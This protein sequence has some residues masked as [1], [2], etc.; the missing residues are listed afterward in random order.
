MKSRIGAHITTKGSCEFTVWAPAAQNVEV[1]LVSKNNTLIP[2]QKQERGYWKSETSE[3]KVGDLYLYQL[4]G[5]EIWPDPASSYQPQDVHG[6]SAIVDHA[7]FQWKDNAWKGLALK[8][9]IVYELHVGTFTPEGTFEGVVTKLD[10]LLD[11][12]ITTIEL[13]P[14]GQFPGNRNWGYDGVFPFAVQHS[15]GGPEGLKKLINACHEKGIAVLVDAV[16]NHLGPEGNCL[17]K[18]GPYCT[19]KY[20]IP[21]GNAMNFD[22]AHSDEVRN[23]FIQNALMWFRDYHVDGLRLD[24]VDAYR[25]MR[26]EHFL[27]ELNK[28][29]KQLE[30]EAGRPLYLMGES[31][32]NDSKYIV[33][34]EKGGYGLDVHWADEFHHALHSLLTG[35]KSGY[36][37]DYG[38]VKDL[39]KAFETSFVH[40]GQYSNFRNKTFGTSTE[41]HPYTQFLVFAQN[42][43]Q[44]GNRLLADRLS[45]CIS[46]EALKLMAG[47]V[48]ISPSIPL[49]F[50]GEEFGEETPFQFFTS[51]SDEKLIKESYETRQRTFRE[52]HVPV[53]APH[54]QSESL[55]HGSKLNWS[56]IDNPNKNALREFYKQFIQ[57]RKINAVFSDPDRNTL[58]AEMEEEKGILKIE[59]HH[60]T[61]QGEGLYAIL[62]FGKEDTQFCLNAGGTWTLYLDSS[63]TQWRGSGKVAPDLAHMGDFLPIRKQSIV[64]YTKR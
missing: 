51:H 17:E 23:Y 47:T 46:F 60:S 18:F 10:Y 32:L 14:L 21:W 42:H 38:E 57:L 25:D 11:L 13:M 5:K 22:D 20:S 7:T 6:P 33:S 30:K 31:D 55:F 48:L 24:A 45:T 53:E 34:V 43:D 8:D 61:Y 56:H 59:R 49:L 36:Y 15:Y 28:E 64:I 26:P 4:D 44:I 63:D 27:Q 37:A 19:S 3:A 12:G 39:K 41:A 1:Q 50:M 16:Y 35:E 29:V 58:K 9:M 52:A 62:N 40:T 2:L 54:P